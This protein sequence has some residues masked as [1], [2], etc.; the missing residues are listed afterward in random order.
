[1]RPPL[2]RDVEVRVAGSSA[3][4]TTKFSGRPVTLQ[5]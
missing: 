2:V 4:Q 5:L 3:K 1:M